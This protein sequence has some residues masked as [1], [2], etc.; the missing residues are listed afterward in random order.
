MS[1]ISGLLQERLAN[2]M[3]L[4][5]ISQMLALYPINHKINTPPG[6]LE[7]D[8]FYLISL[9]IVEIYQSNQNKPDSL[10]VLLSIPKL[11]VNNTK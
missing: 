2:Y 5:L 6:F 7:F 8:I 4:N 10:G 9:W 11:E 3:I 1:D